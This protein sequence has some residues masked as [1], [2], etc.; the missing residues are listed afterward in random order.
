M[1]KFTLH[2]YVGFGAYWLFS[3]LILALSFKYYRPVF[4]IPNFTALVLG[5]FMNL[6]AFGKF[7]LIFCLSNLGQEQP[8][9]VKLTDIYSQKLSLFLLSLVIS[10]IEPQDIQ[11]P[12]AS[13]SSHVLDI[14]LG[15]PAAG[16][17]VLAYFEENNGWKLLGQIYLYIK[18]FHSSTTGSNGRV[19]WVT[20]NVTLQEGIY[21]LK[22]MIA[23]YYSRLNIKTFYPYA[24]VRFRMMKYVLYRSLYN[25]FNLQIVF[26]V[27]DA[28]QHYH[29]PLTLSPYGYS[30][31]RGS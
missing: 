8:T 3:I 19:P 18:I 31:Y 14:S 24:E 7:I 30:T 25:L 22:F 15:N 17:T 9:M 27:T 5:C 6:L 4:V 20:P 28:Q 26:N 11:I 2:R 1:I 12:N 29:V 10:F 13:I 16:V 23:D 21:K